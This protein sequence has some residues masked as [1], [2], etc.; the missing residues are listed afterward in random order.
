MLKTTFSSFRCHFRDWFPWMLFGKASHYEMILIHTP[1]HKCPW[2]KNV[3]C[4][5]CTS[6]WRD[7]D[8]TGLCPRP[9]I[10][11]SFRPTDPASQAQGSLSGFRG[12]LFPA[13]SAIMSYLLC[14]SLFAGCFPCTITHVHKRPI[15]H[16]E[17][18]DSQPTDQETEVLRV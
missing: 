17:E 5:D 6:S 1:A 14:V 10:T 16:N 18:E 13:Q 3:N 2:S 9:W 12:H 11:P 8:V 15:R 7:I 4:V